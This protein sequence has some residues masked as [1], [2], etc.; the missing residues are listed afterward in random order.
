M[1]RPNQP[2]NKETVNIDKADIDPRISVS[3]KSLMLLKQPA[4]RFVLPPHNKAGSHLAGR[5]NSKIRGRGLNF[6][7][8]RHYQIGDDVRNLDWP[9]TLRTGEPHVRVYSEEKDLPVVLCIDQRKSMF[10][11]SIDTM[12]SVVA[13]QIAT[14]YAWRVIQNNDRIGALIFNDS[15]SIWHKPQRN[16]THVSQILKS[17]T[18]MNNALIEHHHQQSNP[19][20]N[21]LLLALDKLIAQKMKGTLIILVSDFSLLT[22][23]CTKKIE[24]LKLHNDFVAISI[25]DE[26]EQNLKI[27]NDMPLSDG[28][29]QVSITT[30]LKTNLPPYN[31]QLQQER[32]HLQRLINTPHFKV[33]ELDTSGKHLNQCLRHKTVR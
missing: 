33:V 8:Y 10:F 32:A 15:Q 29:Y 4:R 5:H 7:E 11:A 24:W 16:Q 3:L 28:K 13:A 22:E 18:F 31:Q 21:G 2:L 25:K 6:E 27:D 14:C 30:K 9:V 23:Q 20:E 26:M 19:K 1:N 17:I 12:K